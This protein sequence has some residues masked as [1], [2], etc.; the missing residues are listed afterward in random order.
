[1]KKGDGKQAKGISNR[2][3][4]KL[5]YE[6]LSATSHQLRTPLATMQSSLDLLEYYV[7]KENTPRQLHTLNKL[8]KTLWDIQDTL[9]KITI[10]YKHHIKKQELNITEIEIRKFINDLLN[11]IMTSRGNNHLINVSFVSNNN[12]VYADEFVLKHILFNIISNSIK[13][14]PQGSEIRI[15]INVQKKYFEIS[16]KD[17][18]IGI[19]KKHLPKLYEPF[20]RANN[21]LEYDGAGLGLSIVKKLVDL[22]KAKIECISKLNNGTEFILTFTQKRKNANNSYNRR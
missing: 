22:H 14:S 5:Q 12:I 10:L 6:F 20:F 17:E 9:N 15:N 3:Y 16:I 11:D 4:T 8:K 13:F 19:S 7:K 1:M 2:N 18:G 21:A